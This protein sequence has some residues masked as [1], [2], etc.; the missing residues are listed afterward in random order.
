MRYVSVVWFVCHVL[1][2]LPIRSTQQNPCCT[3]KF[4]MKHLQNSECRV[5]INI[6]RRSPISL[7]MC[8][9]DVSLWSSSN[10]IP[11]K[12][13]G[14]IKKTSH[15]RPTYL[16]PTF[17]YILSPPPPLCCKFSNWFL[18]D[19]LCHGCTP[20][21]PTWLFMFLTLARLRPTDYWLSNCKYD[22]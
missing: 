19:C 21:V 2:L 16:M 7:K 1:Q 8:P 10:H 6:W 18:F 22:S 20:S 14:P 15:L 9:Y 11:I 13:R 17:R 4:M 5:V 3:R 12:S